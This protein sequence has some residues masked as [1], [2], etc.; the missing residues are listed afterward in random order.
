MAQMGYLGRE[1]R[2]PGMLGDGNRGKR[3]RV[4]SGPPQIM[5]K[6]F[7]ETT[8]NRLRNVLLESG[9]EETE[10]VFSVSVRKVLVGKD[11]D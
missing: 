11:E 5:G 4:S 8:T 1:L 10:E 2:N 3:P 9:Q 6:D 7:R